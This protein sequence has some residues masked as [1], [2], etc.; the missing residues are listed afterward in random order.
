MPT[1]W[2]VLTLPAALSPAAASADVY[3]WR[4]AVDGDVETLANFGLND[5]AGLVPTVAPGLADTIA[6]SADDLT[7]GLYTVRF[8]DSADYGALYV[9]RPFTT[10]GRDTVVIAK[11]N[12]GGATDTTLSFLNVEF[13]GDDAIVQGTPGDDFT[14]NTTGTTVAFDVSLTQNLAW[15]T[16][17]LSFRADP[18]EGGQGGTHANL[19]VSEAVL[20]VNDVNGV[21][22]SADGATPT[23]MHSIALD[24]GLMNVA[25][26]PMVVD[27]APAGTF[28]TPITIEN[29]GA[30][31]A[32]RFAIGETAGT[33]YGVVTVRVG[34]AG[35]SGAFPASL[36]ARDGG[37]TVGS[38]TFYPDPGDPS[39][40]LFD[41]SL[42]LTPA[43][44]LNSEGTVTVNRSGRI[45]LASGARMNL[46]PLDPLTQTADLIVD[47]GRV[48]GLQ[49]VAMAGS[50]RIFAR[51]GATLTGWGQLD[52]NGPF[53]AELSSGATLIAPT[54]LGALLPMSLGTTGGPDANLTLSGAGTTL[55]AGELSVGQG[56]SRAVVS[57]RDGATAELTGLRVGDNQPGTEAEF[58]IEDTLVGDG[59]MT[60]VV[61]GDGEIQI[62]DDNSWGPRDRLAVIGAEAS[63]QT[64]GLRID[65][66]DVELTDGGTL[67]VGPPEA[68]T[69]TAWLDFEHPGRVRMNDGRLFVDRVGTPSGAS[70]LIVVTGT[71]NVI[72]ID[73]YD[74]WYRPGSTALLR[75]EQPGNAS[76]VFTVADGGAFGID[77]ALGDRVIVEA[78][79]KVGEVGQ[80]GDPWYQPATVDG[81]L[82]VRTGG[83]AVIN[84]IDSWASALEMR[85]GTVFFEEPI[86]SNQYGGKIEG[87]GTI[88]T[89][90]IDP[91]FGTSVLDLFGNRAV[92][93]VGADQTLDFVRDPN[94]SNPFRIDL[95][96]N[97]TLSL[98]G[99]TLNVEGA[100]R[101][102]DGS[103]ADLQGTLSVTDGITFQGWNIR[104]TPGLTEVFGDV[105]VGDDRFETEGIATIQTGATVTFSGDLEVELP[106]SLDDDPGVVVV[107]AGGELITLGALTGN[108][109]NGNG[110]LE[111][112]G[113]FA[114]GS[115]DNDRPLAQV[116]AGGDLVL[117][118]TASVQLDLQFE[119]PPDAPSVYLHDRLDAANSATLDG[120]LVLTLGPSDPLP[121]AP[122]TLLS[123]PTITG[124]FDAVA[125]TGGVPADASQTLAVTYTATAV[126]AQ[127]ALLGDANLSG[128]VEQGDLNAVLNNWGRN[129]A[130][131]PAANIS[132][133]TGD[134]NGDGTI[135]QSDLNA[136]LN[137]W[138]N[139][140]AA[141]SFEGFAIP[142]PGTIALAAPLLLLSSRQRRAAGYAA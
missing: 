108:G 2:L 105:I 111:V 80:P 129:N 109:I 43:G 34:D 58:I 24:L 59:L 50:G 68:S 60:A 103:T 102:I 114:P 17:S 75:S 12:F 135:D 100:M 95:E 85:G 55:A 67:I 140:L 127:A 84:A 124:V 107:E 117:T 79:G 45:D 66:A 27:A 126:L 64:R 62:G 74:L 11:S 136:V 1:A 87:F 73:S 122:I 42:E 16:D 88:D 61:V 112:R 32:D 49:R 93:E 91:T 134:F 29:G 47:G 56:T 48:N 110:R 90:R 119:E 51:H 115:L 89:S 7:D 141:P 35:G 30:L 26:G 118:A 138:G 54:E 4:S 23:E 86:G 37:I 97:A 8:S 28:L 76:D 46:I 98:Q 63:L 70:P 9:G 36:R 22:L 121:D 40:G 6:L 15:T 128:V 39:E 21:R 101:V 104:F 77:V 5:P 142:E 96:R 120:Q 41:A 53:V 94:P 92:L 137:H 65:E 125:F 3:A 10:P 25:H 133:T 44:R 132:W 69:V 13:G 99:G 14:I 113:T 52:G 31:S 116:H 83:V 18:V 78:G 20:T 71:R 131:D 72:A 33:G 139:T 81:K 57:V 38:D 130:I 19:S 82:E 106:R 123:A